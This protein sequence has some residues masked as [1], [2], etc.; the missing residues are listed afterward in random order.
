MRP[1]D[2]EAKAPFT[3]LVVCSGNTCRSP[4]GEGFLRR[5][6]AEHLTAPVQVFSAGTAA[7]AGAPVSQSAQLA[8]KEHGVDLTGKSATPLT[9]DLVDQA[10]MVLVMEASHRRSVI[11]LSPSA[12]DKTFLVSEVAPGRG[13]REIADPFGGTLETYRRSFSEM[14]A[15]LREGLPTIAERVDRRAARPGRDPA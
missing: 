13:V 6:L 7:A 14:S 4:F 1:R 2:E 12:A 5:L 9:T 10:D 8:A 15:F 3:I 11:A